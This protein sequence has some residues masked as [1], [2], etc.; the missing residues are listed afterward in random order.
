MVDNEA[1]ADIRLSPGTRHRTFTDVFQQAAVP[2]SHHVGACQ[3]LASQ[4][5]WQNP[6]DYVGLEGFDAAWRTDHG[7]F[8]H[9]PQHHQ[10]AGIDR[11]AEVGDIATGQ[12]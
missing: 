6:V 7:H 9:I 10:A 11:N 8:I 12:P 2:Q 3:T 1:M 4:E 5:T